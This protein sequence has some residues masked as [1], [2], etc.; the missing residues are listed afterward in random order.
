MD[1]NQ[2]ATT[3]LATENP[4][5]NPINIMASISFTLIGANLMAGFRKSDSGI[6]FLL[7]PTN[8][9]TNNGMTID[10]MVTE[11][12]TLITGQDPNAPQMK[13]A[14]IK[15]SLDALQKEGKQ[16]SPPAINPSAIRIKLQQAFLYYS[17]VPSADGK[18]VTS[19]NLEY[20]FQLVIITTGLFPEKMSLFNLREVSFAV[21]NTKRKT[22]LAQMSMFDIKEY[23]ATHS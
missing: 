7:T 3:T 1:N 17:Y 15:A 11:V 23:L 4:T 12:N 18:T 22:I 8:Q 20:A 9:D 5:S 14:D 19:S 16:A 6:E 21:W 10:E 2:L 13:S